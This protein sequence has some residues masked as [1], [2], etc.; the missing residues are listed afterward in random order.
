[1]DEN[2]QNNNIH[3]SD[4][5]NLSVLSSAI[6]K[7]N[8]YQ[9]G[10][11]LIRF[12]AMYFVL[13]HHSTYFNNF[14]ETHVETF[15]L[16]LITM[17]RCI[18]FTCNCLFMLLTGY[19]NKE[20]KPTL[21]YYSK[22]ISIIIEYL[23][24]SLVIL[25]FRIYF[26][27]E[28]Y[29]EEIIIQGLLDFKIAPYSWYVNMYI[30]LFLFIPFLNILYNNIHSLSQKYALIILTIIV[31]SLPATY[32]RFTWSYWYSSFPLIYYFIGC[33]IREYQP[34]VK[35][36]YLILWINVLAITET[37]IEKYSAKITVHNFSN[38]GS[39]LISIS[40]FLLFYDLRAKKKN[41]FL[42]MFR[43]IS[44][45]SLSCFLVSWIM[46]EVFGILIF[47][48]KGL[49]KF[50]ERFPYLLFT[51]PASFVGSIMMGLI[52]H[53]F[54]VLLTKSIFY[55]FGKIKECFETESSLI[56]K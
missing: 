36:I 20:K 42:K 49:N 39:T 35:R 32:Y 18:T 13:S 38:L 3:I 55:L 47:N 28:K 26:R 12:I 30:G 24:S 7:E 27:K 14:S 15:T 1:M 48:K 41:C 37:I 54:T 8:E 31:F 17:K 43:H 56:D 6:M 44:D 29:N 53:N 16:F 4:K 21:S 22:I 33:F 34:K 9:Y 51:V 25:I 50:M 45:T 11:D 46:E 5:E 10:L 2:Q 23:L 40:I 52:I 19:L